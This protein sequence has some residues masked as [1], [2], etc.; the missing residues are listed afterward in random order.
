M[1]AYSPGGAVAAVRRAAGR[2]GGA[3]PVTLVITSPG[4]ISGDR[5]AALRR[6][7][8]DLVLVEPGRRALTALAPAV[9]FA[10]RGG[11]GSA[12]SLPP[13][14]ALPAARLAG[15]AQAG[16]I[17]YRAPPGASSCYP[18]PGAPG[19]SVITYTAGGRHITVL[20]SGV[21]LTN[22]ALAAQGNAALALN[23]LRAHRDIVWLVPQPAR[24]LPAPAPAG[25][26]QQHGP[27]LIPWEAVLVVIQL[28][29]AVAL[30]AV[31]RARRLG[32]LIA[33]RLPVVVRA[34]ETVEGHG[35]LYQARRARGR[36]ATALRGE[37][38]DCVLPAL[39]LAGT[40]PQQAVSDA[41]AARTTFSTQEIAAI[42][43]GPAPGTDDDLVRLARSLDELDREVRAQ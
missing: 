21:P 5:A 3:R 40:H 14:C 27:S 43:F 26:G 13:R 7:G 33:E 8:A 17:T 38:L 35:R 28:A 12:R 11:P 39:G 24:P 30:I 42:A 6:S 29:I 10:S 18:V 41:L 4:L 31:W 23:L 9:S 1:P 34:S 20:G 15:P 16:G 25:S 19:Y 32:P 36:A 2:G 37:L 22:G